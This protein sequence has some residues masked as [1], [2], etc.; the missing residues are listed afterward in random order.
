MNLK[1]SHN[2]QLNK[3]VKGIK[4]RR[5]SLFLMSI[6][7]IFVIASV[8]CAS[9]A[10]ERFN[11]IDRLNSEYIEIQSNVFDIKEASDYLTSKCRQYV[12]TRESQY[13]KDYFTEVNETRRRENAVNNLYSILEEIDLKIDNY[14]DEAVKASV[15]LEEIEI[16]AM[17]LAY[18]ASGRIGK[19]KM[20]IEIT[21]YQLGMEN[22]S[23]TAEEK[24]Q[25]AY[26]MVFDSFY[27]E[28][29]LNIKGLSDKASYDILDGIRE[30][31]EKCSKS[32]HIAS[33]SLK[34]MLTLGTIILFV[35]IYVLVSMIL[36]PLARS[37]AAIE[38]EEKI[39]ESAGYELNYLAMAY[40]SLRER[41]IQAK[42]RLK[43]TAERDALTGLLNRNGYEEIKQYYMDNAD[44]IAFMIID[45]DKFKSINDTLGHE[46]GDNA[47]QTIARTIKETFRDSDYVVRFGGDEFA[48]FMTGNGSQNRT[49]VAN[50]LTQINNK[51]A[52][53][54]PGN[55]IKLSISAGVSFSEKGF[56]EELFKQ[57]DE[58][59]YK[60]KERGR[61]GYSFFE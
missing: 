44:P 34:S 4:I 31:I 60:T 36:I 56:S 32:Y 37:V 2:Y 14:L 1:K 3:E 43:N 16:K 26:R 42:K 19:G 8:V 49:V 15:E 53:E 20:P 47:L 51:L 58:A 24:Q 12:M 23:L 33:I 55:G 6:E 40:N 21:E 17:V 35:I 38:S 29:C 7:V 18:D 27:T 50:K 9:I 25:M 30:Y 39:R 11:D 28:Q 57:A 10:A 13:A 59:L 52:L 41:N 48:V 22:Q 61:C 45:V 5:L 54:E 46:G